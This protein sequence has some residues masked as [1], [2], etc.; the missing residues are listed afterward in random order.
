MRRESAERDR[1]RDVDPYVWERVLAL[2]A[3]ASGRVFTADNVVLTSGNTSSLVDYVTPTRKISQSNNT[4]RPAAPAAD[5]AAQNA[6]GIVCDGTKWM[7][8]EE[9]ASEF[10]FCHDG[11]GGTQV[12][13]VKTGTQGGSTRRIV[14]ATIQS[15]AATTTKGFSLNYQQN[16]LNWQITNGTAT[17]PFN[18]SL[19]VTQGLNQLAAFSISYVEGAAEEGRFC[20]NSTVVVTGVSTGAPA[21]DGPA[22]TLHLFADPVGLNLGFVGTWYASL[23]FKRFLSRAERNLIS[24]WATRKF[25]SAF[26]GLA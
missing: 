8:S 4:F 12:H 7:S 11:T 10:L 21:L 20:K 26:A 1:G 13:F 2:A 17:R 22:N 6:L 24:Y 16:N 15:T 23:F 9:A 14:A 3:S 25:G 5:S 19:A 18:G